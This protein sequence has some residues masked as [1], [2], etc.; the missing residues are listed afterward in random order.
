VLVMVMGA[1][2]TVDV[3]VVAPAV[4]VEVTVEVPD[5]EQALAKASEPTVTPPTTIP[6]SFR[7]S[8]LEIPDL[9]VFS[10]SDMF[11]LI[12]SYKNIHYK[13]LFCFL[14]LVHPLLF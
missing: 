1:G 14:S 2:V 13:V 10:S 3:T 12:A 5:L 7:N 6:A 9:L 8:L 4:T 11:L